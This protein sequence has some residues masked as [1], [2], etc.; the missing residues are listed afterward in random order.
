MPWGASAGRSAC[1]CSASGP[2]PPG[3]PDLSGL[4]ECGC[5]RR[6]V[7]TRRRPAHRWP[8]LRSGGRSPCHG[9]GG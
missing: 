8:S 3:A 9:A 5:R 1:N 2:C 4:G 6:P 7:P